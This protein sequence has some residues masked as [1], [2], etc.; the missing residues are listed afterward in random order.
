MAFCSP[1]NGRNDAMHDF[2]STHGDFV[3]DVAFQVDDVTGIYNK[4][5]SRGAISVRAPE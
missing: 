5:T 4:A 1:I 2:I 3:R